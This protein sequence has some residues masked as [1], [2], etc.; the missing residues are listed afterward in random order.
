MKK[1]FKLIR[2][3]YIIGFAFILMLM[4][5]GFTQYLLVK[6]TPVN[7]TVETAK[8][9]AAYVEQNPL[10]LLFFQFTKVKLLYSLVLV[11]S[12]YIGLYYYMR[13][14]LY[15]RQDLLEM[16]AVI[17]AAGLMVNFFNDAGALL[18]FLAQK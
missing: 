6:Y 1:K 2:A 9:V 3:D 4:V 12:F 7:E 11:P 8:A 13:K 10:A 5:H 17:V 16:I 18:G 15:K 14:Q